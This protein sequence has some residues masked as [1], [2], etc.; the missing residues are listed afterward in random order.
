M[1]QGKR[2]KRIGGI[3]TALGFAFMIISIISAAKRS[4]FNT[5]ISKFIDSTGI[6]SFV[7]FGAPVFIG[8]FIL[9]AGVNKIKQAEENEKAAKQSFEQ[10]KKS[11]E[12]N[13][14]IAKDIYKECVERKIVNNNTV[15]PAGLKLIAAKYD[16]TDIREAE[17]LYQRGSV[18]V[19]IEQDERKAAS[20]QSNLDKEKDEFAKEYK[21]AQIHGKE[22]YLSE[23]REKI[24]NINNSIT[25]YEQ[26]IQNGQKAQTY[27]V[28]EKDPTIS[29]AWYSAVAGDAVG[30][31]QAQKTREKNQREQENAAY[32]RKT[33]YEIEQYARAKISTLWD[34]KWET[35]EIIER[36]DRKL[37]DESDIQK[38]FSY[39]SLSNW[40][41]ELLETGNINVKG[42]VKVE[43]PSL[44]NN[45]A[46][47]DGSLNIDV[48]DPQGR[49]IAT[50]FYN[51]PGFNETNLSKVGFDSRRKIQTVCI[52]SGKKLTNIANCSVQVKPVHLWI[53]EK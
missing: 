3:I 50:G 53:I 8:L 14:T 13:N 2:L 15:D 51:A 48:M 21:K 22:K 34:L 42:S 18:L 36:I 27:Y 45:P 17:N 37:I 28:R 7:I 6:P 12:K 4:A 20:I 16:I 40:S 24:I 38:A 5:N 41:C 52:T 35:E 1:E 30:L 44:L 32:I 11:E 31:S 26:S 46:V 47:V 19:Q 9:S 25:Y 49:I 29:A 23:Y 43:P 33:G 39:L 10:Q